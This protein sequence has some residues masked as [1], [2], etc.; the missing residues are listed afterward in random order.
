MKALSPS[1]AREVGPYRLVA[2][3]GS[4]AMGRVLLGVSPDGRRVAVKQVRAEFAEDTGFRARF[5]REV[6]A[7]RAVSGAYTAAV[8]DADADAPTP[9]LASVFV[10]GPSLRQAVDA[11]GPL[12]AESVRHLAAGLASALIEIHR[13]GLVHRDLKP[14]NVLLT[15]DGPRVIDFGIARAVEG[16]ESTELTHTGVVIGSPAFMSPEQAD[17]REMTPA[18]DV[19]SVGA[20]LLLTITGRSPFSGTSTP[21]TLYNVVH[22][23]PDMDGVPDELR[24]IVAPCLAKDPAERPSPKELL[25]L[26][27]RV[28]P[29]ERPW[30]DGVHRLIAAQRAEVAAHLGE[31]ESTAIGPVEPLPDKGNRLPW[32]VLAGVVAVATIGLVVGL[33][34]PAST[35]AGTA[36]PPPPAN[37]IAALADVRDEVLR[38]GS[39]GARVMHTLDY[40]DVDGGLRAWQSVVTGDLLQEIRAKAEDSKKTIRQAKSVTTATILSAAVSELDSAAGTATVLAAVRTRVEREGAAPT[41]KLSRI[42]STLR[43][44][45]DGWKLASLVP[46]P[47]T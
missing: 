47:A 11:V 6:D 40:R 24:A 21:Q 25:E 3:L 18:S 36:L 41:D 33:L 4:G 12:P 19:F 42:E 43:R 23:E 9:W 10:P 28:T 34:W 7:S 17:G 1:D 38:A 8:M 44:T 16:G 15:D 35:V 22:A 27:G 14:S 29:T 5:R 13:A 37:E 32:L 39:E 26:V 45:E 2:E 31:S 20:I 30:P 46:V